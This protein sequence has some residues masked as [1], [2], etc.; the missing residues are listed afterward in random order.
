MDAAMRVLIA[1]DDPDSRALLQRILE[2]ERY[3]VTA[4]D[5][6]RAAWEAFQAAP[7]P[8]VITDWLMPQMGGLELCRKIR[9]AKTSGYV[10]IILV[11]AREAKEDLVQAMDAGAN[12]YVTKPYDRGELLARVRSG[13]RIVELEQQLSEKNRLLSQE[14][15]KSQR[16][17]L[18]IFP[19]AVAERLKQD[20]SPI[21]DCVEEATVLFADIHNFAGLAADRS[22]LQVVGLLKEVFS[23]FD[24]LAE[25]FGLEKIKTIGDTYMAA[26]GVPQPRPDHAEAAADLAL[27]MQRE[28]MGFDAGTRV[29]LRLRIGIDSGPVIAGVIGTARLA[30]DLWGETVVAAE[31]VKTYGLPGFIQVTEAAWQRLRDKYI[32]E[33]RGEF[34]VQGKGAVT[35]YLLTGRRAAVP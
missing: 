22:P 6:G 28:M 9:A 11:T 13:T 4:A 8:L 14:Q 16:L 19:S 30:Y 18:S 7:C 24:R 2:K 25:R 1:E 33:E 23:R 27:A 35:T 3:R 10:Y 31:Q 12:D 34:F 17:L 29:P 21:A 32:L 5:N 26:S 20:A 15:E